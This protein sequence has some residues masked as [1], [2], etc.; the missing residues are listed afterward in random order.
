MLIKPDEF[1]SASLCLNT[2][3]CGSHYLSSFSLQTTPICSSK[4]GYP[5]NPFSTLPWGQRKRRRERRGKRKEKKKRKKRE[6]G[7]RVKEAGRRRGEEERKR[8]R[9]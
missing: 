1:P 8:R 4:I 9:N 3:G 2:F 5:C 6:E 7:R